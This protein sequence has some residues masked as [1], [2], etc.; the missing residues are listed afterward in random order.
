MLPKYRSVKFSFFFSG[1][2]EVSA[3]SPIAVRTPF[4]GGGDSVHS[5][6][7]ATGRR[8]PLHRRE[9]KPSKR[10]RIR[11]SHRTNTNCRVTHCSR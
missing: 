7:G 4:Q 8:S 5:S 9:Q 2:T 10:N 6:V 1:E 3:N 11:H